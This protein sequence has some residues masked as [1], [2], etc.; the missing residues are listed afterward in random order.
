MLHVRKALACP[1]P[2]LNTAPMDAPTRPFTG[3]I[4][5]G[6]VRLLRVFCTVAERG[7]FAAAE[8]ELQIGLPSI[9]R[10]IK[11]LETRLGVR[12]CQRGRVGFS[13]T[14]QGAQVYAASLRFLAN[15]AQFESE[16][17]TVHAD[18]NGTLALGVVDTLITDPQFCLSELLATF[19][20]RYPAVSIDLGVRTS[21]LI[22]QAVLDGTL[23]VGI[24]FG[25]RRINQLC[26]RHLY[27][28]TSSLY[29][30]SSHPLAAD[31]LGITPDVLA[32][33]D[34]VGYS[35]TDDPD[36][37]SNGL[38]GVLRPAAGVDHMEGVATLIGTGRFIGFLP[39]HYV[40]ALWRCS[41][42]QKIRPDIFTFSTDIELISHHGAGSP[43]VRAFTRLVEERMQASAK[44]PASGQLADA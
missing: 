11:D 19:K 23:H 33:H 29:C 32:E 1:D 34:Y 7:G 31:P 13:L 6:D 44:L 43:L 5:D 3:R 14:D 17:R 39:D 21:N 28:E 27:Q 25:R 35:F 30:A 12:L 22:E 10:Y 36:R 15:I 41:D 16:I 26:Y 24:I 20:E 38:K 42:F 40:D 4:S 18:L 2:V 37:H 8:S 9:S